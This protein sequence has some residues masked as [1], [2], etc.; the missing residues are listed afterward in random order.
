MS[1]YD[2]W[3]Q[4]GDPGAGTIICPECEADTFETSTVR[5]GPEHPEPK[6]YPVDVQ[7]GCGHWGTSSWTWDG[8]GW[9]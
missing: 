8:E 6:T 5:N 7:L 1:T 9:L 3:L 4:S 2:D